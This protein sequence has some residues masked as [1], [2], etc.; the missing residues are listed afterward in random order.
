MFNNGSIYKNIHT[1]IRKDVSGGYFSPEEMTRMLILCSHEKNNADYKQYEI[2]RV[3]TDGL[4]N[5]ETSATITL[6]AGVGALPANYWH[7]KDRGVIIDGYSADIVTD[8]EWNERFYS[9]A[10][11][12]KAW[13]PMARII[14]T[15]IQV[16]PTSSSCT[17]EYLKIQTDPYFDYYQDA[18]DNIQ[19][20]SPATQYVLKTG[21]TY[22]D[23]DD[24]TERVYPYTIAVGEVKSVELHF[25][26]S[27]RV[28]VMYRILQKLGVA[29]NEELK[30][31][32]GIQGETKEQ[33]K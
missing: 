1:I 31:Q 4:R 15:N 12:P 25:P 21:E 9:H 3:I 33:T 6:T 10:L 20:L 24:G 8:K 26:E 16:Y 11:V 2:S 23:K 14:G 29:I 17:V 32:Y 30:L 19:Y 13:C 27:E 22:L 5:I 28:D 7:V 18:D